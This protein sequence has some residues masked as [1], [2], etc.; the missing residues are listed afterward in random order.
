MDSTISLLS[1]EFQWPGM[2][3]DVDSFVKSCIH[4]LVSRSGAVV[5][6]PLSSALHGSDP[7]EVLHT[8]FLYLGAGVVGQKYC[9][10]LRDDF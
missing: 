10:L 6:R 8:E 9:L 2:R 7:N 1:D 4:C 3:K 5:P